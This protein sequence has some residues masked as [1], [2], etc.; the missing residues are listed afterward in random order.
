MVSSKITE[1]FKVMR[2]LTAIEYRRSL[3]RIIPNI[4]KFNDAQV[5]ELMHAVNTNANVQRIMDHR[6][7]SAKMRQIRLDVEFNK[8]LNNV[9]YDVWDDNEINMMR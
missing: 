9:D 7:P 2:K 3:K 8:Q 4:S 1:L 6:I 5:F